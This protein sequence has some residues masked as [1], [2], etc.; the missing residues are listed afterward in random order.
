MTAAPP[1]WWR[2]PRR[3]SVVVDNPS[4]I[5]PHAERLVAES[6]AAGDDA[7]LCRTHDE[8]TSGEIAF[9]LG[10][11]KI[12]PPEVLARN[13]RNL[14]V[15]QSA[16]PKGRGFAPL[17]WQILEGRHE[18]PACLIEAVDEV[19]AGPI[20]YRD[21]LIFEGHELNG[22]MRAAQGDMCVALC[23]RFLDAPTPPPGEPQAGTPT[24]YR[25]RRPADSRLDPNR[26]LGDQF[27]LL[28]IVDN[29]RYPAFFDW[30]GHR[31]RLLI[32]KMP[33]ES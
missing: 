3:I 13:R 23:R 33:D 18:I 19:D 9:Y 2:K 8:V 28:R 5:L 7:R 25:R 32:D 4:W 29:E 21:R 12:T 22:E 17:A 1:D 27:D 31:Y 6:N 15:H 20:I 16:L 11:V 10:C 30:R 24:V 26:S 14:V